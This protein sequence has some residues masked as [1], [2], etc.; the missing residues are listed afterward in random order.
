MS[1]NLFKKVGSSDYINYKKR[2]AIAGEYANTPNALNPVKTNG[3]QYNSNFKFIP[4]TIR[5]DVSNCLI[6]SQ[7]YEALQDYKFGLNYL[8]VTCD[9]SANVYLR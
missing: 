5:A 7:N 4:T 3:S 9:L 6:N 1:A 8:N 2:V